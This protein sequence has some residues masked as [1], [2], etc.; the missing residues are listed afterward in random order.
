MNFSQ[1]ENRN[2]AGEKGGGGW[3]GQKEKSL[4]HIGMLNMRN[5][6]VKKE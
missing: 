5:K 6:N 1:F 3:K 4:I 2:S